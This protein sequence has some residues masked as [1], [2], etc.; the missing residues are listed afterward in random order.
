MTARYQ[1]FHVLCV[2]GYLASLPDTYCALL[3]FNA[4]ASGLVYFSNFVYRPLRFIYILHF[5]QEGNKPRRGMKICIC[6]IPPRGKNRY[7]EQIYTCDFKDKC[8]ARPFTEEEHQ[9]FCNYCI[10]LSLKG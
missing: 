2:P 7:L 10:L 3:L 6:R 4:T 8:I 1:R 5:K 9:D